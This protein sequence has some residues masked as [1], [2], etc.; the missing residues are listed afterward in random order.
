MT[1]S[2]GAN[3]WSSF[4]RVKVVGSFDELA[5][6]RFGGDVNA[7]VWPRVLTGDFDEIVARVAARED[8]ISTL[9]DEWLRGLGLSAAGRAAVEILIQD[10]ERLRALGLAPE[11]NCIQR[12]PKD[13][14]SAV[15]PI[16][17]YSFHV[18]SATVEA[19][20]WLC[21]YTE[22][23]SEGLLNEEALKCVDDPAT[24]AELL[25]RYGGK[26]DAD[27]AEYLRENCYDLHYVP[28]TGARPYTF[29]LGHF[30]RIATD[31]PGSPVPP[32]VHR[33]PDTIPGRPPRLQL[34]S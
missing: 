24:R 4:R 17:V 1:Q 21:S 9:E 11:L 5:T 15:V 13:E 16:D 28:R 2:V 23:S 26:D 29:G 27:F 3:P 20:T 18:D 6:T 19:D 34:I 33:A 12:Y 7:L 32:C 10:Q 22:S 25:G 8:D 31:Y 30:W 14:A